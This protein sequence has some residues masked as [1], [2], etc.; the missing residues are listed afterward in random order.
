M[1]HCYKSFCNAHV[2][3]YNQLLK[4]NGTEEIK[5]K[6]I[7]DRTKSESNAKFWTWHTDITRIEIF[8]LNGKD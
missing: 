2:Y 3:Y 5:K 7:T 4:K 6:L 1:F 8:S